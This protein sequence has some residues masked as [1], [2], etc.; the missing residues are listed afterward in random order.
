MVTDRR[1]GHGK[2]EAWL[3]TRGMVTDRRHG[4]GESRV[5]SIQTSLTL[6][7]QL[8]FNPSPLTHTQT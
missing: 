4:Y 8:T 5:A 3:R 7:A 6:S 1:H 2:E